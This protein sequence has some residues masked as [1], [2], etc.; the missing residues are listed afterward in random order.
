ASTWQYMHDSVGISS[1]ILPFSLFS[2]LPDER[3]A[4]SLHEC[5]RYSWPL[6][7]L[8]LHLPWGGS[9]VDDRIGHTVCEGN[10]HVL[11]HRTA[12]YFPM[13]CRKRNTY[14]GG[15]SGP[16]AVPE[17]QPATDRHYRLHRDAT[18][19]HSTAPGTDHNATAAG[20][21]AERAAATATE[22]VTTANGFPTA[23]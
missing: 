1:T 20:R 2:W 8:D 14:L 6:A 23:D 7:S 13:D 4:E 15:Q 3:P 22:C 16:G 19:Q 11:P 5:R 9:S 18:D 17:W 10:H 12:R 21:R